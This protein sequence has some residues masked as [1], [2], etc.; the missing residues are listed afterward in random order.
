[1]R[2][3][4]AT[5]G[6]RLNEAELATWR[7]ELDGRGHQI[8]AC[9]DA[10]EVVVVNTCA[11]TAEAARK[12]RKLAGALHREAPSA[13]L[14]MTGCYASLEP[15]RAAAAAG[16]DLVI[17]N[18][19]K[20][21]LVARIEE[22]LGAADMPALAREPDAVPVYAEART[23]AFVK[24]A[25]GCRNRCTFCIVT[26]AR[27]DERSRSI[28]D[29]VGEVAALVRRG[30]REVVLT[31]VHLGG[32]GSDI[33]EDLVGLVG[34]VL[35]DTD[36]ERL[37]LSSLEPWDLPESFHRLWEHPRLMPHLHLPLQ[38]GCDATL[39]RMARRCPTGRYRALVDDLRA[40]IDGLEITSDLIVGFP[41]ESDDEWEQTRAFVESIGFSHVHI[42]RYSARQGTAAAR[43]RGR[44]PKDVTQR[45][46][47]Q[48]HGVAAASKRAALERHL[49]A[50]RDVLWEGAVGYTD[51]YLR[52]EVEPAVDLDN[53][54]TPARLLR[55]S[56]DG[57]RLIAEVEPREGA[58]PRRRLSLHVV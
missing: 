56:D 17:D 33:G 3:Y 54:I 13:R 32:Y 31:A 46:S 35:A 44:V 42:F 34:A 16:V 22:E 19:D 5:L 26:V 8:A 51:N 41:G 45:R 58:A 52:V 37:R 29:V 14:V 2:V 9:P 18:R 24:V 40:H 23:R 30:H 47:R 49:G 50:R 38:S 55:V 21:G 25:D 53:R 27:G 7:R 12:S 11:V 57:E 10:A 36:V 28:N 43:M 1:M 15:E 6:C 39:K 20:A 48:I 4:L